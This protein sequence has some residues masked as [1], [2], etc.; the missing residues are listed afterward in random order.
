MQGVSVYRALYDY[1][2]TDCDEVSFSENDTILLVDVID[3]DW[4]LGCVERTRCTGLVP[5]N[6][7]QAVF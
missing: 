2:A 6:Y 5:C 7:L 4:M 1:N 3:A